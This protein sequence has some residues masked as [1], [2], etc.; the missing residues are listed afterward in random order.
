MPVRLALLKNFLRFGFSHV[1]N[2]PVN[3]VKFNLLFMIALTGLEIKR[4]GGWMQRSAKLRKKGKVP[5]TP[6]S[7]AR[8]VKRNF[9]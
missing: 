4:R 9:A 3:S 5:P 1:S 8:G 2:S 7:L 6:A